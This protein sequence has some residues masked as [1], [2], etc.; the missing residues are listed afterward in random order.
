[1]GK[2]REKKKESTHLFSFLFSLTHFLFVST[3]PPRPPAPPLPPHS[4]LSLYVHPSLPVC[5][6]P[7]PLLSQLQRRSMMKCHDPVYNVN[8][9]LH[10]TGH[11]PKKK[12]KK[13]SVLSTK[14][15]WR[16]K[17]L[18]KTKRDPEVDWT[19]TVGVN[20]TVI[21]CLS[22]CDGEQSRLWPRPRLWTAGIGSRL[23]C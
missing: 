22:P 20:V 13:K 5:P 1:M 19:G 10:K 2:E 4:L 23:V 16:W 3:S 8:V 9:I 17:L 14:I 7:S 11:G 18:I 6:S 15:Q 12:G 21:G